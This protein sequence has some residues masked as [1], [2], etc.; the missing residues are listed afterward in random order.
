MW[1]TFQSLIP[2][3][4]NKFSTMCFT[5]LSDMEKQTFLFYLISLT[6]P[7]R[8]TLTYILQTLLEPCNQVLT[9]KPSCITSNSMS[10]CPDNIENHILTW[11]EHKMWK[12]LSHN[13]KESCPGELPDSHCILSVWETNLCCAEAIKIFHGLFLNTAQP[14]LSYLINSHS[15]YAYFIRS[16][17][18][19][20]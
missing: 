10:L 8:W 13:V 4:L 19:K 15:L 1:E 2:K 18:F 20:F 6:F 17:F 5:W 16:L 12:P 7:Y 3:R 11:Q 14:S 9:L